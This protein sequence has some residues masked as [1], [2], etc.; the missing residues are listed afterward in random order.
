MSRKPVLILASIAVFAFFAWRYSGLES[1]SSTNE[2]SE[3]ENDAGELV[4]SPDRVLHE[5]DLTRSESVSESTYGAPRHATIFLAHLPRT[6]EFTPVGAGLAAW[7]QFY[8]QFEKNGTFALGPGFVWWTEDPEIVALFLERFS[9]TLSETVAHQAAYRAAQS[10]GDIPDSGVQF[11]RSTFE[12]TEEQIGVLHLQF[13]WLSDLGLT[14][15]QAAELGGFIRAQESAM[16]GSARGQYSMFAPFHLPLESHLHLARG[17]EYQTLSAAEQRYLAESYSQVL[18]DAAALKVR[19]LELEG[20]GLVAAADLGVP[21]A[22]LEVR[23]G[24]E[25]PELVHLLGDVEALWESFLLDLS[26]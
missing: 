22:D 5:S 11:L 8:L 4:H 20:A 25:V 18:V 23:L 17:V 21:Y 10:S 1:K 3:P 15:T 6:D 26:Q 12:L 13:P 19:Y 7:Q 16:T 2:L 9:Q 14:S 24:K